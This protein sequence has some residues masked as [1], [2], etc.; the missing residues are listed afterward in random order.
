MVERAGKG[1]NLRK[2]LISREEQDLRWAWAQEGIEGLN[3]EGF[4]Q[5]VKEIREKTGFPRR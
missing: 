3:Q 5:R 1:S 4:N 2:T